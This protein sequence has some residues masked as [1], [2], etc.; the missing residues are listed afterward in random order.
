MEKFKVQVCCL[1]P[2]LPHPADFSR[3]LY[4]VVVGECSGFYSLL[5]CSPLEG[6]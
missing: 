5:V 1:V 3:D 2:V 4:V 6:S